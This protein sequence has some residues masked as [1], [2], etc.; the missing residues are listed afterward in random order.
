MVRP[1]L[2][3]T[4]CA[5]RRGRDA[6]HRRGVAR[7]WAQRCDAI[8]AADA[9]LAAEV[10]SRGIAVRPGFADPDEVDR[11]LACIPPRDGFRLSPQGNLAHFHPDADA[12][13]GLRPFFDHPEVVDA[14]RLLI[15]DD[16]HRLRSSVQVREHMGPTG[17]FEGF[18]HMDTWQLRFKAFLYL[19]DVTAGSGA[20]HYIPG[21]HEG[22][23]RARYERV[24]Q[25][26]FAPD[27]DG[28]IDS[29]VSAFTGCLWPYEVRRL[30]RRKVLEE[31]LVVE[32]GRGTLVVFDSRGLHR[33]RS[34]ETGPRTILSAHWIR[35]GS[36]N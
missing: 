27:A 29:E 24:I 2:D 31:P 14:M 25:E 8:D 32:G 3:A 33:I 16:A 13:A 19:T 5:I 4:R 18:F 9:P 17:C 6:A 35:D 22:R 15:G 20:L 21:S 11:L 12:I 34:L 23:W 26:E 36:H 28:Y 7:R 30:Q 1:S 10:A